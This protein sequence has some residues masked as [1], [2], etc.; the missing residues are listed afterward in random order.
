MA[1]ID[2]RD[3]FSIDFRYGGLCSYEYVLKMNSHSSLGLSAPVSAD[4]NMFFVILVNNVPNIGV[5]RRT[6]H[7]CRQH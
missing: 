7:R 4:N 1:K 2:E 5:A 6:V 3:I